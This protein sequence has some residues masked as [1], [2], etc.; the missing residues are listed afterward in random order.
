MDKEIKDLR[1]TYNDLYFK[2]KTAYVDLA[3]ANKGNAYILYYLNDTAMKVETLDDFQ[4]EM[5]GIMQ[6]KLKELYKRFET[7]PN[8][9]AEEYLSGLIGELESSLEVIKNLISTTQRDQVIE[10]MA[11]YLVQFAVSKFVKSYS[12]AYSRITSVPKDFYNTRL[13]AAMF[14]ADPEDAEIMLD[15]HNLR[16]EEVMSKYGVPDSEKVTLKQ[17]F[18]CVPKV[19]KQ[20][21]SNAKGHF[22]NLGTSFKK[23]KRIQSWQGFRGKL[24]H[25]LKRPKEKMTHIKNLVTSSSYRQYFVH[26]YQLSWSGKI[27]K[28]L[29]AL[30]DIIGIAVQ[31][32]EWKKVADEVHKAR[33]KFEEYRNK[34]KKEKDAEED[35]LDKIA[36]E[37]DGVIATFKEFSQSFQSFIDNATQ[38]TEFNDVLGLPKLP[39]DVSSP[40]FKIDFNSIDKNNIGSAQESIKQFLI[41]TNHDLSL[42]ADKMYARIILYKKVEKKSAAEESV[43][44][45]SDSVHDS[46]EDSKSQTIRSY[47][48]ELSKKD[49]VC[50]ISRYLKS[51][52]FYDFYPL[53]PFRPRCDV[54]TTTFESFET[55]ARFLRHEQVLIN[56]VS[57]YKG[58]SMSGLLTL[59]KAAYSNSDNDDLREFGRRITEHQVLCAVSKKFPS[60]TEFDF[61]SL[62]P[63][64]PDCSAVSKEEFARYKMKADRLRNRQTLNNIVS[65]Y[66]GDSLSDLLGRVQD[67]YRNSENDNIRNFGRRITEQQIICAVSQFFPSKLKF[68][69]ISLRSFRPDCSSVSKSEFELMKSRA[70][71]TKGASDDVD[72]VLSICEGYNLCP[73]PEKIAAN[74]GIT[75]SDAIDLIKALRPNMSEYCGTSGCQCIALK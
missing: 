28:G 19:F 22:K 25:S 66:N 44:D 16:F 46:Y 40:F 45:I 51:D 36:P 13:W 73:C 56:V 3:L 75:K 39:V 2:T 29:G 35:R 6:N 63:F 30:G 48:K 33:G 60:R 50:T 32:L 57:N 5:A 9:T 72:S 38:F 27:V 11:G 18:K 68:D 10:L 12:R 62:D 1:T 8:A 21:L 42:L 74:N 64:R 7:H 23:W 24:M 37:W 14:S 4:K 34:L 53:E 61:I 31:N 54:N 43:Q 17:K 15:P 69:F 52:T 20:I 58:N 67:A 65:N 26:N 59:I 70:E 49:I 41:K 47:G 55:H 71:K